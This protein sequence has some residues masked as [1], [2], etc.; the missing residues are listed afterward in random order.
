MM[1]SKF[2]Y[3]SIWPLPPG[4]SIRNDHS[5]SFNYAIPRSQIQCWPILLNEFDQVTI[6]AMHNGWLGHQAWVLRAWLSIDPAGSNI[7]PALFG[8]RRNIHLTYFGNSWTFYELN[9]SKH[10][11]NQADT[12]FWIYRDKP[13]YFNIQNTCQIDDGYYLKFSYKNN[14]NTLIV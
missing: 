8:A 2:T 6:N 3:P 10:L 14:C 11:I 7:L 4:V 9:L 1:F 13:Y 12:V 5:T